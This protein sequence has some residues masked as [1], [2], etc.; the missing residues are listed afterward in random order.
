MYIIRRL[1]VPV[2]LGTNAL[3]KNGLVINAHKRLLYVDPD[4][5]GDRRC[6]AVLQCERADG[7][8]HCV[9]DTDTGECPPCEAT[10]AHL[11]PWTSFSCN[12]DAAYVVD[13][14]IEKRI[15][16]VRSAA[17]TPVPSEH[18]VVCEEG[19]ETTTKNHRIRSALWTTT[20]KASRDYWIKAQQKGKGL[21]LDYDEPCPD[22]HS[23]LT[24]RPLPRFREEHPQLQTLEEQ[25]VGAHNKQVFM[26]VTNSSKQG[27]LIRKG[28]EL[29][30]VRAVPK[31]SA[32]MG[33]SQSPP[34]SILRLEFDEKV[35][36]EEGGPPRTD[37]DID[38]LLDLSKS[39][40][41]SQPKACLLYTSPSPRDS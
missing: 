24:V 5:C 16:I 38:S 26:H 10:T 11:S 28:T 8:I 33:D 39:I 32:P 36:F 30:S 14:D 4:L 13:A 35:P 3:M 40:D 19:D 12:C 23:K 31:H 7:N 21:L 1:G 25:M 34:G 27:I 15:L 18:H 6:E 22:P 37:A 29:A 9:F 41:P 17:H 2:L 20:L